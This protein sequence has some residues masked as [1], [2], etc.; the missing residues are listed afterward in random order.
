MAA[1]QNMPAAADV[2]VWQ[3]GSWQRFDAGSNGWLAVDSHPTSAQWARPPDAMA[4]ELARLAPS[5]LELSGGAPVV[6]VVSG[7][8][9]VLLTEQWGAFA[10]RLLV[11]ASGAAALSALPPPPLVVALRPHPVGMRGVRLSTELVK[12]GIEHGRNDPLLIAWARRTVHAANL[13]APRGYPD[14]DQV[15][16]AIFA[17]QKVEVAFVKDPVSGEA[18]ARPRDLLCLDPNGLCLHAGDCDEQLI[19]MGSA[20][21]ALGIP[22]RLV[23]RRYPNLPQAHIVLQYQ[24]NDQTWRCIDPSLDSGACS[25]LPFAE[26]I[27]MPIADDPAVHG[28]FL[29]IGAPELELAPEVLGAYLDGSLGQSALPQLPPEIAAGWLAQLEGARNGLVRARAKLATN[30]LA[31]ANVRNDLGL[32]QFDAP[33]APAAPSDTGTPPGPLAS[34]VQTGAWTQ[35]AATAQSRLLATCDFLASAID[36]ALAGSRDLTF[37]NGDLFVASKA[38]DPYAV[39]MTTNAQNQ[40]VPMFYGPSGPTGTL[41]IAPIL[42]GAIVL[43]AV[44]VS[45]AAAWAVAKYTDYLATAHHDDALNKIA[46]EQAALVSSGKTTAE[47]ST[48]AIKA[49]TDL[50]KANPKPPPSALGDLLS[51]FPVVSVIGAALAGAALGFG[52]SR[53]VSTLDIFPSAPRRRRSERSAEAA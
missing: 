44:V 12:W 48:A 20:I 23:V 35:D 25:T 26:Q 21:A 51:T 24:A 13:S 6:A 2:R 43:G 27:I 30:A 5:Y 1:A 41:G 19:V 37:A 34:Y 38:S 18:M 15:V 7:A 33:A 29:G 31:F 46:T 47:Q 36:D 16:A 28:T 45:L 40:S 49:L 32:P 14:A 4:G 42:I 22:V 53:L 11:G 10:A 9:V 3:G 17:E 39:L 8:R 52:A 50:D